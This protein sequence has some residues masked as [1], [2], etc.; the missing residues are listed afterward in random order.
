VSPKAPDGLRFPSRKT[1]EKCEFCGDYARFG[2][3]R[4]VKTADNDPGEKRLFNLGAPFPEKGQ[5][6][7]AK[8]LR[9][10]LPKLLY[11]K[12]ESQR[13]L[14]QEKQESRKHSNQRSCEMGGFPFVFCFQ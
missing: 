11:T 10:S 5:G 7:K 12:R 9:P 13:D 2:D 1:K 8:H 14:Y 6:K 4:S 3:A